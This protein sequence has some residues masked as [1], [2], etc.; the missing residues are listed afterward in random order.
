MKSRNLQVIQVKRHRALQCCFYK[1]SM[2]FTTVKSCNLVVSHR[3]CVCV[4][5][6]TGYMT[7][8]YIMKRKFIQ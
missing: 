5:I 7:I 4:H 3:Q 8:N 2:T 6:Q 1:E